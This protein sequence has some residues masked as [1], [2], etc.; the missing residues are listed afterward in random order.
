[1][2]WDMIHRTFFLFLEEKR[3]LIQ[4]TFYYVNR[5]MGTHFFFVIDSRIFIKREDF[6]KEEL[7]L[8][9]KEK[10]LI[11]RWDTTTNTAGGGWMS[12]IWREKNWN[13]FRWR[14]NICV[15]KFLENILDILLW[16]VKTETN[17]SRKIS[18]TNTFIYFGIVILKHLYPHS[19]FFIWI[20]CT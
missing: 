4:T 7:Q 16:N 17:C 1:M 2:N 10:N 6:L 13:L 12:K 9:T 14:R 20:T 5:K 11:S 15:S 19:S 8:P 3:K 18:K